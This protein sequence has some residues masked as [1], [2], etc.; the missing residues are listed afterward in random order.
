MKVYV[1]TV[2]QVCDDGVLDT[3]YPKVFSTL[4]KAKAE[5]KAFVADDKELDEKVGWKIEE[6]ENSFEAWEDGYYGGNHTSAK[7]HE[8]EVI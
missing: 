8:L 7:I 2:D 4:E 1:M 3:I 6:D 5:F